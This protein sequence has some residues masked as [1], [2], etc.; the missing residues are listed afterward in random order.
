MGHYVERIYGEKEIGGTQVRHLSGVRF[1]LLDKPP[2]PDVPPARISESLQHAI[3]NGLV[4]PIV[5]LGALA[6]LAWKHMR[7]DATHG[8]DQ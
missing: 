2:L 7:P 3:Y 1:E 5:F 4:A 6:A 8:G